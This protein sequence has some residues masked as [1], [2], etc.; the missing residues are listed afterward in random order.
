[1]ARCYRPLSAEERAKIETLAA[2]WHSRESN[3]RCLGVCAVVD[4]AAGRRLAASER[5]RKLEPTGWE[6]FR[7]WLQQGWNPKQIACRERLADRLGVSEIW[8]YALIQ[9]DR[10]SG[11]TLYQHLRRQGMRRK[12]KNG[13]GEADVGRIRGA[14]TSGCAGRW[15][16]RSRASETRRWT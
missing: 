2:E 13:T 5:P 4:F 14:W 3:S 11:G 10:T 8:L 9:A 15:W 12:A 7:A 1:M 6:C 16:R